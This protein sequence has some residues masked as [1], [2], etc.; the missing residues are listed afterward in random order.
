MKKVT[1]EGFKPGAS[2]TTGYFTEAGYIEGTPV[3]CIS[4][5]PDRGKAVFL[6]GKKQQEYEIIGKMVHPQTV[7][8]E[9]GTNA[10]IESETA[11]RPWSG[12][13][14]PLDAYQNI[15]SHNFIS[16]IAVSRKSA[17]LSQAKMAETFKIPLRTIENWEAG[18]N[19]PPKWAEKLII[20]KLNG[21][22]G[23]KEEQ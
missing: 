9:D 13:T 12:K 15:Y 7:K 22:E 20:E 11:V 23:R 1:R 5:S 18:V 3:K 4:I 8:T 19:Q 6:V 17:G 21:M 14:P 10:F 16:P 2:Y